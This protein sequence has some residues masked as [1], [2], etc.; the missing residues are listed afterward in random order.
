MDIFHTD[1]FVLPLPSG[2]RFPM[3]RYRLLRER[4]QSCGIFLEQQFL[5]PPAATDDQLQLVHTE[6]WVRR[7]TAGQLSAD[8]QRRIGFP[9]SLQMVERSRRSVGAT[10]SA[11]RSALRDGC[12]ANLAGGTHHAFADRGAGY[13]VFND[14]AVAVRTLQNEGMIRSALI[15][16]G[17]V[18]QGDGTACI[19]QQDS[20]VCTFSLH[21]MK[22]FPARKQKSDVDIQLPPGASDED[23]LA[24]WDEGLVQVLDQYT[25][26]HFTVPDLVFYLA[27]ADPFVG[28]TLGGLAVSKAGLEQRDRQLF[29][30][31]MM[32][33]W[34]VVLTMAGGYAEQISDIVDIQFR[35]I[36]LA[37]QILS[38]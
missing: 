5:I 34:P 23:Y 3:I 12:A 35:T 2:H 10:I 30:L 16:D 13:C 9:W 31:C 33:R 8:E 21:A 24:A 29:A 15:V 20:T 36:V 26:G 22:A 7:V 17:D 28:D 38:Q 32:R 18:H 27:G 25:D 14:V 1:L 11:A 6:D 4:L 37:E 19:F